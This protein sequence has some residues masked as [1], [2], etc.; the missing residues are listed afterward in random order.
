M[1]HREF[2]EKLSEYCDGAL[3]PSESANIREHLDTCDECRGFCL[4]WKQISGSL[5]NRDE[6]PVSDSF[7]GSVMSRIDAIERRKIPTRIA[8]TWLAPAVGIAAMLFLSVLPGPARSLSMDSMLLGPG[9]NDP[10]QWVVSGDRP[11]TDDLLKFVLE[12]S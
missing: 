5:F 11:Q 12:E 4:R 8:T 1:E 2:K 6:K 3:T 10:M 7:V 9:I